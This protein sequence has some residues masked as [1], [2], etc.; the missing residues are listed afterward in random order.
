MRMGIERKDRER[1]RY[2]N[3]EMVTVNLE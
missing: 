2:G 3:R 1:G